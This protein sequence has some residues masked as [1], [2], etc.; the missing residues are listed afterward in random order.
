MDI[1]EKAHGDS[2]TPS[3]DSRLAPVLLFGH[4]NNHGGAGKFLYSIPSRRQLTTTPAFDDDDDDLIIS[5]YSWITPRGW[6]LTLRPAA[7]AEAFLRDPFSSSKIPLSP[8]DE[9]ITALAAKSLASSDA[10]DI[11]GDDTTWCSLSHDPTDARCVVVVVHPTEPVLFYCRPGGSRA[12]RSLTASGGKMYTDLPWLD[13]MVTVEFSPEPRLTVSPLAQVPSMA[14]CNY[15]YS[16]LVDSG[17]ELYTVHFRHSLLCDRRIMLV[18]VHRLD[19]A[20]GE[21]VKADGL[22]SNRAFLVSITQFGVSVAADEVGLEP[23]C[24]YFTKWEDKGMY[25]YDVGQARDDCCVQP[26]RGHT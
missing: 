6:V 3:L 17:G 16:Y 13:K 18:M 9:E 10:D 26:W 5:H 11:R 21:W 19:P 15:W 14:W 25:V 8:P 2:P 7:T 23:N 4:G 24:I 1:N 22:G 20:R 12:M